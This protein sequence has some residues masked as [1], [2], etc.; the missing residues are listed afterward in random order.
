MRRQ[1]SEAEIQAML[2]ELDAPPPSPIRTRPRGV[3]KPQPTEPEPESDAVQA[4][5]ELLLRHEQT[6]LHRVEDPDLKRVLNEL[7]GIAYSNIVDIFKSEQVMQ[8]IG[9]DDKGK[10]VYSTKTQITVAD[11]HDLPREVTACIQ[12]IDIRPT[13]EGDVI[14]VKMYDKQIALEKLMKFHGAYFRDNEQQAK[15]Q[16]HSVMDLL[17][18][19]I[20][21]DGLPEIQDNSA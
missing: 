17:L 10:D 2:E 11:L 14:R 18:A 21:S 5:Q 15:D 12:Q 7:R 19:S 3:Q 16:Q 20:G 1:R 9:V 8:Y 6:D 13:P 4:M